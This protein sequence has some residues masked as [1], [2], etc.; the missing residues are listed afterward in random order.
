MTLPLKPRFNLWLEIEGQVALSSWRLGLLKAIMETG[1]INS[2]ADQLKV[3]YRT[4]WQKVHE[5]EERLGVKLLDTQI[6]GPHGGGAKLTPIALAYVDKLTRLQAALEP[7][8][9]AKYREI[10]DAEAE[11]KT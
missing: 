2:A 8:V 9:E 3:Q 6:G 4:A 11:T 5:M 10:F 7:L 1:S